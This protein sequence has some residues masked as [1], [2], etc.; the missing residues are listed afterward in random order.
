MRSAFHTPARSKTKA[1]D[2]TGHGITQVSTKL[3]GY[4]WLGS[5]TKLVHTTK[6]QAGDVTMDDAVAAT[7]DDI[8]RRANALPN[9]EV[10]IE[11]EEEQEPQQ[12]EDV[13]EEVQ[14]EPMEGVSSPQGRGTRILWSSRET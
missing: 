10:K 13:Q 2:I 7:E 12:V 4:A 5:K 6:D 1:K 3:S 8:D 9:L 14:Q 11:R